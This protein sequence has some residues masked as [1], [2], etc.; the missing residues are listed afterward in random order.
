M[1]YVISKK[2]ANLFPD[3]QEAS[4]LDL[5]KWLRGKSILAIDSETRSNDFTDIFATEII[6]FQIG[7]K[8]DQ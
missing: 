7:D 4:L 1:I 2:K 3:M 8:Y 5:K 6:M